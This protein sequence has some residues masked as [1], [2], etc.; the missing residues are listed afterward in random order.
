VAA[1]D[2]FVFKLSSANRNLTA[3][4]AQQIVGFSFLTLPPKSFALLKQAPC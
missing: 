4:D 2:G 1:G 3:Y